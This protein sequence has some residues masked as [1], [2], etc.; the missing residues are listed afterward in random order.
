MTQDMDELFIFLCDQ[1]DL[2][3]FRAWTYRASMQ[4][5]AISSYTCCAAD[6]GVFERRVGAAGVVSELRKSSEALFLYV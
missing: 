1:V 4:C 3:A 2:S 5:F 6:F